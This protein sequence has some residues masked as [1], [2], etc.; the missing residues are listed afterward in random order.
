ME[1]NS[2]S[3]NNNATVGLYPNPPKYYKNF[4]R[5][6]SFLPPDI[7]LLSKLGSYTTF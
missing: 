3:G 7:N 5:D 1:L 2:N 4:Q 6:D